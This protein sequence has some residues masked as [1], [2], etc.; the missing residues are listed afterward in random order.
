MGGAALA[1]VASRSGTA[2]AFSDRVAQARSSSAS[3]WR[4]VATLASRNPGRRTFAVAWSVASR[5]AWSS[6]ERSRWTGAPDRC[7]G[8]ESRLG[9][10]TCQ[11]ADRR[12]LRTV[13]GVLRRA[14]LLAI[15]GRRQEG[16]ECEQCLRVGERF[17]VA[18]WRPAGSVEDRQRTKRARAGSWATVRTGRAGA[19]CRGV[20]HGG[21]RYGSPSGTS[22]TARA[23]AT[24]NCRTVR[25]R[26][27]WI[28]LR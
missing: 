28:R 26:P 17:G 25:D 1:L 15:F 22:C 5:H 20:C 7:E 14:S 27:G 21:D 4:P 11:C 6:V 10:G 9:R 13:H 12:R 24:G 19:G 3:S 2:A 18:S 8:R 16:R 23:D